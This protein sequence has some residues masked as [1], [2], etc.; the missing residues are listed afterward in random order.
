ME[1]F[2]E[3]DFIEYII[4]LGLPQHKHMSTEELRDH[5]REINDYDETNEWE[6]LIRTHKRIFLKCFCGY[7]KSEKEFITKICDINF[8]KLPTIIRYNLDWDG[9]RK[10]IASDY[11]ISENRYFY[12]DILADEI[13]R[14]K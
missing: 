3:Y 11:V 10:W 12:V 13:D 5:L 6:E 1:Y 9:I 2:D 4:L 7:F 8:D 14:Y